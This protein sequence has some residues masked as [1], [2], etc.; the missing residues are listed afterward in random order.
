MGDIDTNPHGLCIGSAT[1]DGCCTGVG[2]PVLGPGEEVQ[3]SYLNKGAEVTVVAGVP[4]KEGP[5]YMSNA[6]LYR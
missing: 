5:S 3:I 4:R 2:C 1:F 6:R